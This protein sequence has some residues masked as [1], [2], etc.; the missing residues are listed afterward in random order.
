MDGAAELEVAAQ[1]HGQVVQMALQP[2]D[3]EQVGEGLG[4]MLVAAVAGVDEGAVHLGSGH[5]GSALLGMAHG[6]D[7]GIAL[8]GA[9]GVGHALT[10]GGRAGIGRRKTQHLATETEHCG[11][12]AQT[13]AGAGFKKQ[14]GQDLAVTLVSKSLGVFDDSVGESEE[15]VDLLRG[16]IER[17]DQFLHEGGPPLQIFFIL[18]R[19]GTK[20]KP[21]F[22]KISPR[23]RSG[24]VPGAALV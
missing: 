14:C 2:V 4:G 21:L 18:Q 1:A 3:G 20:S 23:R 16:Q 15:L 10:L 11:F 24:L 19:R 17:T 7:V 13:G 12:K 9:H 22:E 8:H 5:G 6:D